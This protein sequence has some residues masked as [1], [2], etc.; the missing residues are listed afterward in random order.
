MYE[1][2]KETAG[3]GVDGKEGGRSKG[4]ADVGEYCMEGKEEESKEI[5]ELLRDG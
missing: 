2:S 1:E 4:I 5:T 3:I